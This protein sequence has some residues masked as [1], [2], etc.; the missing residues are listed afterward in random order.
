VKLTR[1]LVIDARTAGISGDMLLGALIDAGADRTSIQGVLDLIPQHFPK[2]ESVQLSIQEVRKHGF[3]ASQV[4]FEISEDPGEVPAPD[5]LQAAQQISA[6]SNISQEAR[7][8]VLNS[9]ER[10]LKVESKLHGVEMSRTHLHEAGSTDTLADMFGVA[11]ACDRLSV[12]EGEVFC[13]PVAVGGGTI[14]FSHGTV[15]NPAPAT[16]E[17][18]KEGGIAM[19]AGPEDVEL[20]TPTGV[21]MLATLSKNGATHY[22][23]MIPEKIGYGAGKQDLKTAPN[24]LRVI[25][26]RV[27]PSNFR[28]D[29]ETPL[30][31]EVTMTHQEK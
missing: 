20:S 13:T 8:F 26:G 16:L 29:F 3:R 9:V 23:P 12:F 30:M 6:E 11:V 1:V 27:A 19:I 24:V 25:I 15:S 14:S 17:I 28:S 4:I 5:I 21:S 18:L 10:L 22:P 7:S 2:C 31:P